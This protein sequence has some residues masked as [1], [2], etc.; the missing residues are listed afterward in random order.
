MKAGIDLRIDPPFSSVPFATSSKSLSRE[1]SLLD[2]REAR[3]QVS[4]LA[5]ICPVQNIQLCSL[6]L[7]LFSSYFFIF[8]F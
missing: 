1:F 7:S 5:S 2:S 8:P 6:F 4:T 3:Q